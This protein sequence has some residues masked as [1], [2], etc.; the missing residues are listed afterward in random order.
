M[1]R[2]HVIISGDVQGV[3]FRSLI[4][5]QAQKLGLTGWVKNRTDSAVE[6]VFEGDEVKLAEIVELCHSGPEI[7]WVEEVK[8]KEE[9][10]LGE[11]SEFEIIL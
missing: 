8:L 3:G 2:V 11:F 5:S 1:K 10:Y 7:A 6:A 9:E 4:K